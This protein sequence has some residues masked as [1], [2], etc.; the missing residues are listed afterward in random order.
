MRTSISVR[1]PCRFPRD[2][3]RFVTYS[4]SYGLDSSLTSEVERGVPTHMYLASGREREKASAFP[5]LTPI[6]INAEIPA[7]FAGHGQE[8]GK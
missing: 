2:H 5:L 3:G 4:S 6:L 1:L 8:R 7:Q